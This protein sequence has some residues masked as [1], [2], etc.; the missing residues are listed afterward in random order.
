MAL[1]RVG[2][3]SLAPV[4]WP[5]T[6]SAAIFRPDSSARADLR[7]GVVYGVDGGDGWVYHVQVDAHRGVA[8]YRF[9]STA[10]DPEAA[11][12][13]PVMSRFCVAPA[14]IGRALREGCWQKLARYP[15]PPALTIFPDTVQWPA[16]TLVVSVWSNGGATQRDA[17]VEDPSIQELEVVAVFDAVSHVPARLV[18][19]YLDDDESHL[20]GSVWH[21]R[22][23]FEALARRFPGRSLPPGWVPT[24]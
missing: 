13:Q 9:R 15:L 14:S 6:M 2:T 18:A 12:A 19:E 8:A 22:R 23:Q 7:A 5:A 20:R 17:R 1:L 16:G 10:P 21:H 3:R 11:L 24:D 4:P